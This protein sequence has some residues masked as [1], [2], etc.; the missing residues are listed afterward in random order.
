MKLDASEIEINGIKYVPKG[1]VQMAQKTDGMNYVIIRT[2]KAGVH[3]GYLKSQEGQ[4]AILINSRRLWYWDG[5]SSLSQLAVDGTTKPQKCKF[6]VA[7][8][9]IELFGRIETI[10]CSEKARISIQE[11]RVWKQ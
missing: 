6:P 5:A 1:T 10:P 2:E 11:V 7:V 9:S 3:A 8:P 4:E